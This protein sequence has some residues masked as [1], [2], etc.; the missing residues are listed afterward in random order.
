M[1]TKENIFGLFAFAKRENRNYKAK[2]KTTGKRN[3]K[4]KGNIFGFLHFNK[5]NEKKQRKK[6]RKKARTDG[7]T[8]YHRIDRHMK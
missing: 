2:A 4:T 5:N 3:E 6:G 7:Y 1:Q 8:K